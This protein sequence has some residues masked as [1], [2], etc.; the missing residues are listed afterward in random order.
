LRRFIALLTSPLAD[1]EYLR[2]MIPP[3]AVHA[4]PG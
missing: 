3:F 2:A 4:D 1:F